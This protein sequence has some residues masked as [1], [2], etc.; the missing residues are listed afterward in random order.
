MELT[1][2]LLKLTDTYCAARGVSDAT[3]SGIIF[4]NSRT[5]P[6]IR[7]GGDVT[8]RNYSRAVGWFSHNW[9]D[10][11]AW[12]PAIERTPTEEARA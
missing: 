5:I 12:P 8:T 9:P 2:R 7:R 11:H 3:V 1:E 10:D 4:K 6:R